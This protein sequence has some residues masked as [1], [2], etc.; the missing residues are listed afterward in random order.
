MN[1]KDEIVTR[2]AKMEAKVKELNLIIEKYR[3][4]I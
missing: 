4:E 3:Q 1:V 2:F